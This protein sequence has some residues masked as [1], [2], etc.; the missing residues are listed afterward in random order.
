MNINEGNI[1]EVMRLVL[2]EHRGAMA[3]WK[4]QRS[5]QERPSLSDDE[6]EHMWYMVTEAIENEFSVRVTLF[7]EYGNTVL[8]GKPQVANGRLLIRTEDGVER[9][10]IERLVGVEII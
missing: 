8:V 7:G 3:T 4:L 10:V 5:N 1:F 9:V 6:F 2:P